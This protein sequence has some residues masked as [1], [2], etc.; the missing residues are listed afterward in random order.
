MSMQSIG[1]SFMKAMMNPQVKLVI[2]NIDS[3]GGTVD[4]TQELAQMI[5]QNKG[6]ETRC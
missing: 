1:E 5:S 6:E 2:L 4:G 3:P